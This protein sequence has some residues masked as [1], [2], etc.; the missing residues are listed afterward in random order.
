MKVYFDNAATTPLDPEVFEAMKPL[1]LDMYGNPSSTHAHGREV[2]TQIEHARRKVAE[3]LNTIPS[4]IFFTSGGTEADNTALRCS[5]DEYGIEHIITSE[6]EHK[7][8]G[9]TVDRLVAEGKVRASFVNLDAQGHVDMAH[10]ESLVK[11]NPKTMISLMHANNE[12]GTLNNIEAIGELAAEYGAIFHSDTVQTMGHYA[13]DLKKLKADFIVGAAHKF[14]GP[15]GVGFLRVNK[16]RPIGRFIEGGGQ[17]R[18][19]RGG[20]ENVYG[21]V[22][23]AKALEI[24][25]REMD[26]HQSHVQGLKSSMIEQLKAKVPGVDFN[27]DI[28][29]E[30]SLYTVLNVSFPEHEDNDMLLFNLDINGISASGGSACSSGANTGSHVL[31]G[32]KADPNRQGIRFSFSK[33]SKQ[34]EVDF[35]VAKVVEILEP[36]VV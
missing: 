21:I 18:N 15:K 19:H 3:L 28:K 34:E 16:N 36:A 11:D 9:Q 14:H 22:G 23:L 17:E 10:L 2:R 27:G 12:I 7:A 13:H 32:I 8:V 25:Y 26:E 31:T 1:M 20:T 5:V 29:P 33:Y 24:A 35:V 6:I 30:N 4:E